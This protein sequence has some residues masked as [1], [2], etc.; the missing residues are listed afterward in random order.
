M[1][2]SLP[3]RE[4]FSYR[5]R[6]IRGLVIPRDCAVGQLHALQCSKQ[7]GIAVLPNATRIRYRPGT[8]VRLDCARRG[9]SPRGGGVARTASCLRKDQRCEAP[10]MPCVV[11]LRA[12][13]QNIA[14]LPGAG[15][16]RVRQSSIDLSRKRLP[17]SHR[18][19][20]RMSSTSRVFTN[21]PAGRTK[22][23][24]LPNIT[25]NPTNFARLPFSEV[26]MHAIENCHDRVKIRLFR[27]S[28]PP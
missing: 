1:D 14:D 4:S 13:C 10:I 19:V 26:L 8:G 6:V 17:T 22:P 5:A 3:T 12:R 21:P 24:P 27:Q 11:S 9:M 16:V 20:G 7:A 25:S 23:H 15:R 18:I 28:S 2:E